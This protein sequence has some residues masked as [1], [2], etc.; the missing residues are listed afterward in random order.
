[1]TDPAGDAAAEALLGEFAP[2]LAAAVVRR[3][4]TR[5]DRDDL[6]Q[7]AAVGLLKAVDS[8]NPERGPF[9]PWLWIWAN[10][11]CARTVRKNNREERAAVD[12]RWIDEPVAPEN[13]EDT[14]IGR[15]ESERIHAAL[16]FAV[17]SLPADLQAAL[18]TPRCASVEK[19]RRA[20]AMLRHPSQR[21]LIAGRSTKRRTGTSDGRSGDPRP[22][23]Q[24][25]EHL[26]SAVADMAAPDPKG[27]WLNQAACAGMN[28]Q[29]FFV[30]KA[31]VRRTA[32]AVCAGCPVTAECLA[33]AIAS[34]DRGG[35]RA[36]TTEKQR[37]AIRRQQKTP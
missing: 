35:L 32:N 3:H 8:H 25:L 18:Q 30:G 29:T 7:D 33:D 5:H 28:P 2:T 11:T 12:A 22:Q 19:R 10:G 21:A 20:T 26:A 17:R 13:V 15:I 1:M 23:R 16:A 24:S 14:V 9:G 37:R 31:D 6:A 4:S 34:P 36:G 27:E